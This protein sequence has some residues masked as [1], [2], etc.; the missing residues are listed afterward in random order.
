M[1]LSIIITNYKTGEMTS[2]CIQSI[3]DTIKKIDYEII[4]VDN[5]SDDDLVDTI[6]RNHSDIKIIYLTQN[7]GYGKANNIGA[8]KAEGKYLLILNS[9][10]ILIDD[11]SQNLIDFYNKNNSGIIGI[12]LLN[13][14]KLQKT[15]GYFPSPM[16]II[17]KE[18]SLLK[19]LK[20]KHFHPYAAIKSD[21]PVTQKVD[22]ITGAFMFISRKNFEK[23]DGFDKNIFMYYEDVDICRRLD[24]LGLQNYYIA[25]YTAIHK[26]CAT[27]K[28]LPVSDYNIHKV[29]EKVSALYYL[30]KYYPQ[31]SN[32]VIR[33]VK[34][35]YI[36]KYLIMLFKYYFLSYSK[37][38]K[39]KNQYK[40]NSIKEVLKILN[41]N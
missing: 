3:K 20:Y 41:N 32:V 6:K 19:K 18:I 25:E 10:I 31:Y 27:T 39:I 29:R 21:N 36:Q 26:H 34:I 11:F 15:F 7:F 14:N 1:D 30:Q 24:M 16:L 12:K 40:L 28:S 13:K 23:V 2:K 4:V 8:E 17:S 5:N 37:V 38:K 35:I 22:W 9:D 33:L